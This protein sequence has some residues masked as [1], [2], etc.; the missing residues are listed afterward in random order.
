MSKSCKSC[1]YALVAALFI[2]ISAQASEVVAEGRS[3]GN[4]ISS[5]EQALSDALRE[6]VRL[7]AGVNIASQSRTS[8][9]VLDYDRVFAAAFGYVRSYKVLE[10]GMGKDG[11]YHVKIQAEVGQSDPAV[12]NTMAMRQ[13][14]ALKG[15]PRITFDIHENVDGMPRESREADAWFEG[16]AKEMQLVVVDPAMI[17]NQELKLARRDDLLGQG[18]DLNFHGS[19][20]TQKADFVIQGNVNGHYKGKQ[21]IFGSVPRH[22]FAMSAYLRVIRPETGEV[23]ASETIQ[24]RDYIDS[25]E[26]TVESAAKDSLTKLLNGNEAVGEPG[27]QALFRKVFAAWASEL[28]LGRMVRVEILKIDEPSIR[29]LVEK[30]KEDPHVN[31]VWEREFDARAGSIIDVETRLSPA[32]LF[33]KVSGILGDGYSM[34]HGTQHYVTYARAGGETLK[35]L[36]G[37]FEKLWG[38]FRGRNDQGWDPDETYAVWVEG[39]EAAPRS[40]SGSKWHDDGRAPNLVASLSWRNN[41]LLETP[42]ASNALIA[43]WNS[44]IM[45][46]QDVMKSP[47]ARIHGASDES[48]EL[49]VH[50]RGLVDAQWVGGGK[51][52]CGRLKPGRNL[53]LIE[54]PKSGLKSIT[55]RV[56]PSADLQKDQLPTKVVNRVFVAADAGA[57]SAPEKSSS[58]YQSE[59]GR[60]L[61]YGIQALSGYMKKAATNN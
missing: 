52:S 60:W 38:G 27:A 2:L 12:N 16:K 54:D 6:A 56:I 10:S 28:D 47:L 9:Y 4:S 48:I 26:G 7:G 5:R 13:I 43:Q 42:V 58:F 15:S 53:I 33:K 61:Q 8:D 23:I 51:V 14:I 31:G 11:V 17:R 30:L 1:G 44:P 29:N 21:S 46:R 57:S 49:E 59:A 35:G 55:L 22:V 39:V 45:G 32:E 24:P 18:N 50:D 20:I 19:D 34:D 37:V 36:G 41:I 25:N 3:S 40:P